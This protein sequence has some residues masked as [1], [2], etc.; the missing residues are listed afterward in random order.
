M[1]GIKTHTMSLIYLYLFHCPLSDQH[2]KWTT[3]SSGSSWS[4]TNICGSSTI[5]NVP[6]P[7]YTTYRTWRFSKVSTSMRIF[8]DGVLVGDFSL[9]SDYSC[10]SRTDWENLGSSGFYFYSDDRYSR[11]YRVLISEFWF[12]GFV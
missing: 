4:I 5:S 1:V 6:T 12:I 9:S 7:A 10:V 2:I 3:P 11:Y 8:C